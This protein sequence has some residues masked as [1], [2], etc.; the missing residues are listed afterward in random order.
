[1]TTRL[2][3]CLTLLCAS[4]LITGCAWFRPPPPVEIKEALFCDVEEPRRFT[5][6]E[7]DWRAEH[8]PWNLRRD[9]KTNVTWDREC[10][11]VD[12]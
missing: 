4:F 8:A 6:A 5:Q 1:M 9:F 7:L 3:T 11:P 10:N 2:T 12:E